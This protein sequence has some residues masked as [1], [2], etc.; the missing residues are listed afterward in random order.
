MNDHIAIDNQ[1]ELQ[2]EEELD[3]APLEVPQDRRRIYPD[4]KDWSIG[5]LHSRWKRGKLD[6]Q[7]E[8]QRYYVFDRPK[9][10]RLV[11]SILIEVPIPVVYLAE[12]AE[13]T[14]SVID[15]QQRLTAFFQ[16]FDNELELRGLNILTDLNGMHFRDLPEQRQNQF[17]N[18]TIRCIIIK[19]ESDPQIRFEIFERLNTGSVKLNDQELRNCIYRGPFNDLLRDLA[20]NRDW[21][22]LI[23][24][25]APDKRMRDREMILRFFA[26]YHDLLG[27]KPPMRHFLNREMERQRHATDRGIAEFSELFHKS[28]QLCLTVFGERAFKR[29][30]VGDQQDPNGRWEER[31]INMALFDVV[32]VGFTKYERRQVVP[33]SDAVFE[34]L[35][36]LMAAS[37]E[38][39]DAITLGTSQRDRMDTRMRLWF[40]ELAAVLGAPTSEPRLF[41]AQLKR[42][43][44]ERGKK[45]GENPLCALCGTQIR[46]IDD[47]AV[48]H[49]VPYSLGGPTDPS[50]ARLAHRYCNWARGNR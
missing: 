47:A 25:K 26:L 5:E 31:R 41:T 38:F 4:F 27:Y 50:N 33:R 35:V 28:V 29:F 44:F 2:T 48:D 1:I 19:R 23:G 18:G 17:E 42:Q 37:Q 20:E 7:P 16:F 6:L 14:Y 3:E 12:E 45:Q 15:G 36:E 32:M 40:N 34:A 21:Q 13:F 9:A 10:S 24:L 8:F 43:L 22:T 30:T 49:I 46:H 11:E 39:I